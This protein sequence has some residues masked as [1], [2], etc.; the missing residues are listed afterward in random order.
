MNLVIELLQ[1][2]QLLQVYNS[3]KVIK[4]LHPFSSVV[5]N[6]WVATHFFIPTQNKTTSL[7]M[8]IIYV[9]LVRKLSAN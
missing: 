3:L 4:M 6:L 2:L 7:L 5:P 9:L 1:L 8:H